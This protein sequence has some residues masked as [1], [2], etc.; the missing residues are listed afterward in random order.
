MTD[1]VKRTDVSG[2]PELLRL[3]EEVQRTRQPRILQRDSEDLAI[4]IPVAATGRALLTPEQML[5]AEIWGDVGVL[6]AE[7][8]WANYNPVQIKAALRQAQGALSG[9]DRQRLLKDIDE[10]REQDSKTRPA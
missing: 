9:L 2:T 7:S 8:I 6:D 10:A 3:A 1:R 4:V 5:E